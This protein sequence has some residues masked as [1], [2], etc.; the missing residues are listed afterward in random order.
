VQPPKGAK[1]K[2]SVGSK[3]DYN[4]PPAWNVDTDQ[5]LSLYVETYLTGN[6]PLDLESDEWS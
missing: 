2:V 3:L 5:K 4:A 1:G 6:N